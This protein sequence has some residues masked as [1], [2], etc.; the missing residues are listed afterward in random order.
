MMKNVRMTVAMTAVLL[1]TACTK[2]LSDFKNGETVKDPETVAAEIAASFD[3]KMTI[4]VPI[5]LNYGRSGVYIEVVD[6]DERAADVAMSGQ[7]PRV[8]YAAYTGADGHYQGKMVIPASYIGKTL[9]ARTRSMGATSNIP[10]VV[11]EHGVMVSEQLATR[12]VKLANQNVSDHLLSTIDAQLPEQQDNSGKLMEKS[13]DIS[14]KVNEDC[15]YIDVTFLYGGAGKWISGHFKDAQFSCQKDE[16]EHDS[17]FPYD[18]SCDL[19]YFL[20]TDD[21][22]PTKEYIDT[23]YINDHHRVVDYV[24]NTNSGIYG[25]DP[26]K[27]GVTV[28][29]TQNDGITT[30][31]KA[32]TRIGWVVTH[33]YYSYVD[34]WD[35]SLSGWTVPNLYSISA[36]NPGGYSQSIR[37][38]YG[39]GTDKQLIYGFEDSPLQ[40]GIK[41][42]GETWEQHQEHIAAGQPTD[43][44]YFFEPSDRDYNDVLF[45]VKASNPDA[46]VERE[47]PVLPPVQPEVKEESIEGTLLY[48][49]LF[50]AQGDYDMNDVVIT[51]R[52]TKYFDADNNI[53]KLG[54]EFT[55]VWSGADYNS[56]FSFLFDGLTDVVKVF[57]NQADYVNR[58]AATQNLHT[59]TG[60]LTSGG[61]IGKNKDEL[62]WDA[63]NPFITVRETGFEVHLTKKS[64]SPNANLTGLNAYL[65]A[66]V[67]DAGFPFAMN[68]P[69][70]NYIIVP[71]KQRID[72]KYPMFNDWVKSIGMSNTDWY[73]FPTNE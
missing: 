53:V 38:Q 46:I 63:F 45:T 14:I 71:E 25:K 9:Y 61:F 6:V 59:F 55:P 27:V 39:E 29:I 62:T 70:Q 31:I 60:Q 2:D 24:N 21:N 3:Y 28:R 12:A 23:Y 8:L 15:D 36:Y 47:I 58:Y 69:T 1:M 7:Q 37:Y 32:G 10:V 26:K 50:P 65:R 48:E 42:W 67:N 64:P 72:K 73:L 33:P 17:W 16:Y 54:Y 4:E 68:I 13:D 44:H 52:L 30:Q 41:L 22:V 43:Q 19:Y 5:S 49:D 51:Y 11:N 20:Y 35:A 56:S 57:D 66:Y 18:T 34:I 40:D